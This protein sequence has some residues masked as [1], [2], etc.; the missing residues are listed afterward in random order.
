ME[1]DPHVFCF[2]HRPVA[3]HSGLLSWQVSNNPVRID[4][5]LELGDLYQGFKRVWAVFGDVLLGKPLR[6]TPEMLPWICMRNWV[7]VC[8]GTPRVPSWYGRKGC[9]VGF[10]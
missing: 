6:P 9:Y 10:G 7:L 8:H 1:L 5:T 4:I 3:M 2:L